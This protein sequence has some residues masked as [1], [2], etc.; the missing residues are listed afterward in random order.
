MAVL[1]VP[2]E[3]AKCSK[4][5]QDFRTCNILQTAPHNFQAKIKNA[6]LF[7][8]W[9]QLSINHHRSEEHTSELQSH[10]NLVCRLLLAN[11]THKSTLHTLL[12]LVYTH[13]VHIF[14][15]MCI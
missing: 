2:Y 8:S 5:E 9:K 11:K 6:P 15:V 4:T 1:F 3:N 14:F 10:L 7:G 12:N 13:G